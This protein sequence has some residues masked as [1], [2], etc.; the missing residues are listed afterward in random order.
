MGEFNEDSPSSANSFYANYTTTSALADL[1]AARTLKRNLG[2]FRAN[3]VRHLP[4]DKSAKI[5]EIGCGYGKNLHALKQLGYMNV[6]GID[7]SE[8]Q[9]KYARAELGITEVTLADVFDWLP[10][11]TQR[12]D[13]ILLIDVL[14]HLDL[15]ALASLAKLLQDHLEAGA[16]V[17]VQVPNDFAPFNSIRWGDLTHMRAFTPRSIKQ[18]FS[19]A[20]LAVQSIHEALPP[21]NNALDLA[22]RLLWAA[23][24]RPLLS[25]TYMLIRTKPVFGLPFTENIIGVARKT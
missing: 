4:A 17:I 7:L 23:I 6:R 8:E 10:D 1:D 19:N 5:L 12:F 22:R 21:R 11:S 16:S 18:F 2:Y 24:V 14:E 15:A 25:V 9:I 20:G 3:F 13:C